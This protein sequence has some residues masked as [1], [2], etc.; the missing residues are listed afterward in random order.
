MELHNTGGELRDIILK[1]NIAS[2]YGREQI[3]SFVLKQNKIILRTKTF[4]SKIK[5]VDF[6]IKKT[7]KV[8][9]KLISDFEFKNKD[10]SFYEAN[11]PNSIYLSLSDENI[12]FIFRLVNLDK[13]ILL[14]TVKIKDISDIEYIDGILA[15]RYEGQELLISN[16]SKEDTVYIYRRLSSKKKI[17]I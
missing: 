6:N 17:Y 7:Q 8:Y 11:S 14:D 1:K 10:L 2:I 3:F 13:N 12:Y 4:F 16:L 15:F 9:E 5:E